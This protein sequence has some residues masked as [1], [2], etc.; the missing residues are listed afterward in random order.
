MEFIDKEVY[1]NEYCKKCKYFTSEDKEGWSEICN[2]CLNEPMNSN[3]HKP[4]N[5]KEK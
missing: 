1:F 3:S 5:F 2:D 4:I